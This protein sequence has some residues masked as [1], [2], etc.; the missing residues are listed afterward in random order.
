MA[1]KKSKSDNVQTTSKAKKT[2]A[3]QCFHVCKYVCMR[4]CM[5]VFVDQKNPDPLPSINQETFPM[6]FSL[7]GWIVKNK[8]DLQPPVGN[9]MIYGKGCQ[10]CVYVCMYV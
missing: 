7:Q 5:Y 10:V 2:K 9:K 8:K 6:P 4:V 1:S 3:G